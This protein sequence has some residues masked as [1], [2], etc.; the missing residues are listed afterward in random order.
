MRLVVQD[1]RFLSSFDA[2]ETYAVIGDQLAQRLGTRA[3]R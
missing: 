1:G 3:S 2:N